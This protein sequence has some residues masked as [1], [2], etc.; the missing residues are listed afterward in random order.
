MKLKEEVVRISEIVVRIEGGW[1]TACSGW[2][3]AFPIEM[4]PPAPICV[5]HS[6]RSGCFRATVVNF[7]N[8]LLKYINY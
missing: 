2:E 1:G 4:C 8:L 5:T 7:F 6:T 3:F